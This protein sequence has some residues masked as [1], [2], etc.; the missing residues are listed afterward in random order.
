MTTVAFLY[1]E[2]KSRESQIFHYIHNQPSIFLLKIAQNY[3]CLTLAIQW[4]IMLYNWY[5]DRCRLVENHYN[6]FKG[7][8]II[9]IFDYDTSHDMYY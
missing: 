7:V 3:G 1:R 9:F 6:E 5:N 8:T 4:G 2:A